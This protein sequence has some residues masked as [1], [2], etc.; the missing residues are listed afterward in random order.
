MGIANVVWG[1]LLLVGAVVEVWAL[2]NRQAGDTLSE[3]VRAWFHTHTRPGRWLFAFAW[4]AFATWF[5]VHI[6]G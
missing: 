6:L 2:L 1:G 3:R 5:L 4:A